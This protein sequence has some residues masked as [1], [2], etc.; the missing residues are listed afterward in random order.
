MKNFLKSPSNRL[1]TIVLLVLIA[2]NVYA[3]INNNE[4]I[5]HATKAL[6]IPLF[7]SIYFIKNKYIKNTAIAFLLLTFIGD[8]FSMLS[9]D[10]GT[11]KISAV[12]YFCSYALLVLV[13]L[14]RIKGFQFK[15]FVG[16]Y[17]IT[18]FILNGYF[19]YSLY[20]VLSN[21]IEDPTSLF[22]TTL[23][24]IALLALGFVSFAGYLNKDTRQSIV[25]LVMSFCFIFSQIFNFVE[26]YFI[27]YSLFFI[28]EWASY[29]AGLVLFYT[30]V[31]ESNRMRKKKL[32]IERITIAEKMAA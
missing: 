12:A 30:Y 6:S 11:L 24:I 4:L 32:V 19:M 18:V 17:L 22:F 20:D 2:F 27:S 25:F 7:F 21:N 1:F 31:V 5:M 29:L 13:G 8:L 3:S 16:A 23:Q 14:Y 10:P 9:N 15:G 26:T 28:L